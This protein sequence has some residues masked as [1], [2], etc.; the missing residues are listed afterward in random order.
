ML[1]GCCCCYWDGGDLVC[2]PMSRVGWSKMGGARKGADTA[3]SFCKAAVGEGTI[4]ANSPGV[5]EKMS[6]LYN[7]ICDFKG[8]S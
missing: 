3:M 5:V 2:R 7:T 4:T 1:L 8:I 6:F